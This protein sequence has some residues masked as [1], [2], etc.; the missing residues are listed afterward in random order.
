MLFF[1]L[2][3]NFLITIKT[4]NPFRHDPYARF[5]ALFFLGGIAVGG[6]HFLRTNSIKNIP[7]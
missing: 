5:A 3:T 2:L 1:I 4:K 6:I 7:G